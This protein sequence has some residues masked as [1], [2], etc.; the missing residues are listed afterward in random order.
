MA[1][2]SLRLDAETLG[3]LDRLAAATGRS[4]STVVR[5]AIRAYV[6]ASVPV[7]PRDVAREWIGCVDTGGAQLATNAG[8]RFAAA[9][10]E[11]RATRPR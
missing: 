4:K 11:K 7:R 8:D 3:A 2:L 1:N 10:K 6:D 5:D 9:L